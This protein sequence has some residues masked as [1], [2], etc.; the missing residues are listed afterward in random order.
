MLNGI[1]KLVSQ[2]VQN[3]LVV[4]KISI[5]SFKVQNQLS[6]LVSAQMNGKL[7]RFSDL[8]I[9]DTVSIVKSDTNLCLEK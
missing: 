9:L 1:G 5:F 8:V 2:F 3:P 7:D 6:I 4:K